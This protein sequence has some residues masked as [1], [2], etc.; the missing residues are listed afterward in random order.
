MP[1]ARR[2]ALAAVLL[3]PLQQEPSLPPAVAR[4]DAEPKWEE[5]LA[6]LYA[7]ISGPAGQERDWEAFR[8]LFCEGANLM[9]SAPQAD[10]AS[11][12]IV[13]TPDEYVARSGAMLVEAGFTES[14]IG[15]RAERFGNVV[16]AFSAYEGVLHAPDGERRIRGVNSVQL[17]RLAEGWR[18]ANVL[19]EQESPKNPLPASLLAKPAGAG[20]A[21]R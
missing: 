1:F 20:S 18:I 6:R 9:V 3:L 15:R 11:R 5:A 16:H 4:Q 21:E 13:L 12:L 14:E 8:A 7:V 17:V 10:G 19:W 2:A